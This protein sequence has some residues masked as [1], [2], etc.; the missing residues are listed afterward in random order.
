MRLVLSSAALL[1]LS[2]TGCTMVETASPVAETGATLQ[3]RLHGGQQPV[4]GAHVYLMQANTTG[5]GAASISLLSSA[6]TGHSDSVGAYVLTDSNGFFSI[7]NDYSCTP[8]TQVY[9]YALGGNPGA[10]TNSAAGF[11]ALLGSCPAAGNFLTTTPYIWM[12]EVSTVAAAYA[13]A[14]FATDALHVSSSGTSLAKVDIANAFATAANLVNL[15]TGT[16]YSTTPS[17]NAAVPQTTINTL[18]NI[19]AACV[20]SSGP[21]S[22]T[23]GILF[24]VAKSAGS[25]GTTATDTATAAINIAHYP[26]NNP[27]I[28]F[29]TLASTVAFAPS[30]SSAPTDFT[31]SLVYSGGG[32]A[33]PEGI[34]VDGSGNVWVANYG[35]TGVSEILSTGAFAAN[36]PYTGGGLGPAQAI[37]IDASGN[38]WV[39]NTTKNSLTKFSSSGT[40]ANSSGY[41]GGGLSAP[42]ALAIDA[43]G[44]VWVGNSTR[45]S[46]MSLFLS[47]GS[48]SS[49]SP[50][51]G[52]GCSSTFGI[53]IAASGDAWAVNNDGSALV[54]FY[55]SSSP[56]L[57]SEAH[58]AIGNGGIASPVALAI[59]SLGDIWVANGSRSSANVSEYVASTGQAL[60]GPNG[61]SGGGTSITYGVATDGSG[62]MWFAN[63]GSNS[64]SE[65]SSSGV[66]LSPAAGSGFNGGY[67]SSGFSTPY[68]IAVD[69]SGNVWVA[70]EGSN[71]VIEMIGIATPVVTPLVAGLKSPYSIGAQP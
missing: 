17:G 41:T 69:G 32:I 35:S 20:N 15:A 57:G 48:A 21:S 68:A 70:D 16:A 63:S 28:L 38:A 24:S 18:A 7:T 34:A 13:M 31:L 52:A 8:G 49:S 2:L 25:S 30:L 60:T 5:T 61:Y 45:G 67:V 37:A 47:S 53:A 65:F 33:K 4:V 19:L 50:L 62:N 58:T 12:N 9:T 42:D 44:D 54:E 14:G 6:S 39:T 66:A 71:A 46:C 11:L 56:S 10:G 29:S 64:I 22:S 26:G 23:C 59:N 1:C 27:S 51:S 40:P 55:G 36:T 43:N 3:G